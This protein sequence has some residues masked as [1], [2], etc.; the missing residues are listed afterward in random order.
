[1]FI[2]KLVT[3]KNLC[4]PSQL[5][6]AFNQLYN[7][8]PGIQLFNQS[9]SAALVHGIWTDDNI[10]KFQD[11]SFT[12]DSN[13]YSTY[14]RYG[15]GLF[16][17]IYTLNFRQDAEG[18]CIDYVRL[19]FDGARTE[20][21]C[22]RFTS[23]DEVGQQSFFNEGGGIMK[24]HI[25]VNKSIPFHPLQRSIEV[26]LVF[27]AYESEFFFLIEFLKQKF[28]KYQFNSHRMYFRREFC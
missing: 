26:N 5:Q 16:I 6:L 4:P 18:K 7:N 1:M 21:I 11:C 24:V 27:T 25:Y 8:R 12:V 10:Q 3:I 17:S 19:T 13:L 22:G 15:R 9:E 28:N 20:K 23:D 2:T 14:G